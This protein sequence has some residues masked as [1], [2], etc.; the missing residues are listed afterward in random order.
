MTEHSDTSHSKIPADRELKRFSAPLEPDGPEIPASTEKDIPE[1]TGSGKPH[2]DD[3]NEKP[4][5]LR[6]RL[7]DGLDDTF[8]ASDPIAPGTL[9]KQAAE[10]EA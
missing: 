2:A 10:D 8:P 9:E 5:T 1:D 6:D 3:A 7:D 4:Q